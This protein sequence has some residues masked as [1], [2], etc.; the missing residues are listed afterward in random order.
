MPDKHVQNARLGGADAQNRHGAGGHFGAAC[1][2]N[3]VMDEVM[4]HRL[5]AMDV[6][7][8]N[9]I[10]AKHH[11]APVLASPSFKQGGGLL[12]GFEAAS[13]R[14]MRNLCSSFPRAHR[15][16]LPNQHGKG[17]GIR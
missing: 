15:K 4:L 7:V 1:V 6:E 14:C 9:P 17:D 8:V 16:V 12:P 2:G 5:L 3:D 13:N 11:D 10:N